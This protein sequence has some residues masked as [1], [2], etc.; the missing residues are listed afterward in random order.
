M[1]AL[2]SAPSDH[3]DYAE[4]MLRA[5]DRIAEA[6]RTEDRDTI[7]AVIAEAVALPPADGAD[8]WTSLVCALAVQV[9]T[10]VP[11]RERFAWT[12]DVAGAAPPIPE[13]GPSS[14]SYLSAS[15][16]LD[17]STWGVAPSSS[18]ARTDLRSTA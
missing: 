16:C 17:G 12:H 8:P 14:A 15:P 5:S 6:V 11:W 9:D 4:A 13:P 2:Q 18:T 10:D 7:A 1:T 3:T